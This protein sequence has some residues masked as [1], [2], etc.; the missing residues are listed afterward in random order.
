MVQVADCRKCGDA[1]AR[2]QKKTAFS[3][4]LLCYTPALDDDEPASA[5]QVYSQT[6]RQERKLSYGML[7]IPRETD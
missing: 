7:V 6:V 3:L 1:A 2:K 5:V 4:L